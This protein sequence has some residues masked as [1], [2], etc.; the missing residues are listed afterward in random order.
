M[1][2]GRRAAEL[3]RPLGVRAAAVARE[4]PAEE[5]EGEHG[6]GGREQHHLAPDLHLPPPAADRERQCG[7]GLELG[8]HLRRRPGLD[9]EIVDAAEPLA[10]GAVD[11]RA[12]ELVE[13]QGG[14]A[15]SPSKI[16]ARRASAL[17]VRV[18]T[19]PRGMSRKLATSLC[20]S[21][22][23]YASSRTSRSFAGSDSRARWTRQET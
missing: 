12:D 5:G 20:E 13:V 6:D 23:Q 18:F 17:R 15:S 14:H 16:S 9:E 2:R 22:L 4:V 3:Q 11:L 1:R 21:P 19:V 10:L 8:R 7:P